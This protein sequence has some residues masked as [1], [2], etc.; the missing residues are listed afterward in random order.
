MHSFQ[1]FYT[2]VV[3]ILSVFIV[4]SLVRRKLLRINY[5]ILWIGVTVALF[6]FVVKYSWIA[7]M[8][9]LLSLGGPKNLFFFITI[10]FL[11]AICIQFS[12]VISGLV[13]KV[14]NLSQKIALME[15]SQQ[16]TRSFIKEKESALDLN[17]QNIKTITSINN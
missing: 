13:M 9:E 17:K 6:F 15:Y 1:I 10:F 12:I 7:K 14:K 4:I 16:K 3:S 8:D 11:L 5:S 2:V